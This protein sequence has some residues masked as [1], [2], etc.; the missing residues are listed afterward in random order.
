MAGQV[1]SSKEDDE[2]KA[3][4]QETIARM[5]MI[6]KRAGREKVSGY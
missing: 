1:N 2:E 5:K 4:R 3:G 6:M